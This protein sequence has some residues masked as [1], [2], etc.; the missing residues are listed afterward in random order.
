MFLYSAFFAIYYV[1]QIQTYSHFHLSPFTGRAC[2]WRLSAYSPPSVKDTAQE[3]I[4]VRK[5]IFL[6]REE[7]GCDLHE[8][9][10]ATEYIKN[11]GTTT[12]QKEGNEFYKKDLER[13][14]ED[15]ET[16]NRIHH[17]M[18]SLIFIQQFHQI[19][20]TVKQFSHPNILEHFSKTHSKMG[21]WVKTVNIGSGELWEKFQQEGELW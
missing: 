13:K 19:G 14:K 4:M 20:D 5:N 10:T 15:A 17:N 7:E 3:K 16:L 21:N 9:N 18:F 11:N 1:V 8:E 12:E 2:S 6:P